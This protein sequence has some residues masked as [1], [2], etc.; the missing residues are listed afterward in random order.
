MSIYQIDRIGLLKIDI[1]GGEFAVF[2]DSDL[3]WLEKVDQIALEVHLDYGDAV[4]LVEVI[5]CHG[6]TVELQDNDG[7]PATVNSPSLEY[8]YCTHS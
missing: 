8:A 1:E 4:S 7:N 3:R 5:R 2:A 6:F